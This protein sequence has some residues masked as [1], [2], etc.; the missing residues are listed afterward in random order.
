MPRI[1]FEITSTDFVVFDLV[2]TLLQPDPS[3]AEAYAN[4]AKKFGSQ[5]T[6]EEI[7]RE[8]PTAFA[9]VFAEE[10]SAATSHAATRRCWRRVVESLIPDV[11]E[12]ALL[13]EHL[14]SHFADSASWSL[15]D[16]VADCIDRLAAR[17]IPFAIA[18]NF[19][20]RIESVVAGFPRLAG[21]VGLFWSSRVGFAKPHERFFRHVAEQVKRPPESLTLIG[22]SEANDYEGASAAGWRAILLDRTG[23]ST[24]PHISSLN[25]LRFR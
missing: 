9:E 24:T 20:D 3:V 16:D 25:E 19:D 4:A 7:G 21:A 17:E 2:G 23:K 6:A 10:T 11:R 15:Y 12:P 8:F 14:W 5:R 18:S 13:F 22:D 1:E